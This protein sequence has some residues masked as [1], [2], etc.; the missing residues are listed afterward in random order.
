MPLLESQ[1]LAVSTRCAYRGHVRRFV[2]F[3]A[4]WPGEGGDP[5]TD[6]HALGARASARDAAAHL[7][8]P[9]KCRVRGALLCEGSV[10]DWVTSRSACSMPRRFALVKQNART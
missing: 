1:P 2:E 9:R 5:L 7:R 8:R 4:S 10:G 6:S 3:L